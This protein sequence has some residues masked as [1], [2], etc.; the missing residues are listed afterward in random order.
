MNENSRTSP[1]VRTGSSRPQVDPSDP[2]Y[3]GQAEYTPAFLA[4]IYDPLVLKLANRL[5]WRLPTPMIIDLYDTHVADVHLDVGPGTGYLLDRC[6]FPTA[7]PDIELLD[8]NQ[9]VLDA[10]SERIAR[11][12]PR[13][14]RA[15]LL[16]PLDLAADSFGSIALCHVLHCLPGEMGDKA[17]VLG[18]LRPLLRPGGRLFGTTV[19]GAGV[20]HTRAATPLL[21][22]LNRKGV[23]SN[24][25]DDAQGLERALREHFSRYELHV[26][27]N[28]GVFVGYD[29]R[30]PVL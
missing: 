15:D 1:D 6:R 26:H 19:L 20:K 9:D 10:A 17:A 3:L 18:R 7:T 8:I 21:R 27:G 16:K 5:V 24:T 12:Q 14:V 30:E 25:A 13:T 4:H 2:A 11:Y 22:F 29:D 28:V 23:F